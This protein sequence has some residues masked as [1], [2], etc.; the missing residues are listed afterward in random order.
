MSSN[1]QSF[2]CFTNPLSVHLLVKSFCLVCKWTL[3]IITWN[4]YMFLHWKSCKAHFLLL[5]KF[6]KYL[7]FLK[8]KFLN[9][10]LLWTNTNMVISH[11]IN[12]DFQKVKIPV[13]AFFASSL[14]S[15]FNFLLSKHVLNILATC[16]TS[17][18]AGKTCE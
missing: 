3:F 11:M 1:Y 2:F 10:Q 18:R 17:F 12:K 14:V 6:L 9:R 8:G 5:N 13:V 16:L 15:F 4:I 7:H